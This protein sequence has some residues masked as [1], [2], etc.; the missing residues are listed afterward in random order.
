MLLETA[1]DDVPAAANLNSPFTEQAPSH[2][3]QPRTSGGGRLKEVMTLILGLG[4]AAVFIAWREGAFDTPVT[5]PPISSITFPEFDS[6]FS[7]WSQTTDAQKQRRIDQYKGKRVHWEGIIANVDDDSVFIQHK[8]STLTSDVIVRVLKSD[9]PKL[10]SLHKGDLLTY[11]GTITD[12]GTILSHD[13]HDGHIVSSR[14]L[15]PDERATW[16]LKSEADA[17]QP[18]A[19]E[20]NRR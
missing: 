4:L 16:L 9:Q 11:E 7:E 8:A 5:L 19:N 2:V 20:A 3:S 1:P 14:S 10:A 13:L 18:I 15:T 6:K 12:F 17:L